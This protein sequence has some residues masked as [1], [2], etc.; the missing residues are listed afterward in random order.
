[1]SESLQQQITRLVL[2]QIEAG[3]IDPEQVR[4]IIVGLSRDCQ[5]INIWQHEEWENYDNHNDDQAIA[6]IDNQ[7]WVAQ[8]DAIGFSDE[9][10]NHQTSVDQASLSYMPNFGF[11]F[12]NETYQQKFLGLLSQKIMEIREA[13]EQIAQ[14]QLLGG[15]SKVVGLM[16]QRISNS[17]N[18]DLVCIYHPQGV[19]LLPVSDR[20]LPGFDSLY[21]YMSLVD[22]GVIVFYTDED[23]IEERTRHYLFSEMDFFKV[24]RDEV[25]FQLTNG[26]QVELGSGHTHAEWGGLGRKEIEDRL[27]AHFKNHVPQLYFDM[28]SPPVMDA[29]IAWPQWCNLFEKFFRKQLASATSE[30]LKKGGIEQAKAFLDTLELSS[31]EKSKVGINYLRHYLAQH[32]YAELI[33]CFNACDSSNMDRHDWNCVYRALMMQ[34]QLQK[35]LEITRQQLSAKLDDYEAIVHVA[36]Y[37]IVS[38]HLGHQE[39]F[40]SMLAAKRDYRNTAFY[41]AMLLVSSDELVTC[42]SNI[43]N[44][45]DYIL[46]YAEKDFAL[47]PDLLSQLRFYL[48]LRDNACHLDSQLKTFFTEPSE[49]SVID[50]E[51]VFGERWISEAVTMLKQSSETTLAKSIEKGFFIDGEHWVCLE[52]GFAR[53]QVDGTNCRLTQILESDRYYTAL[54]KVDNFLYATSNKT[55]DI[56][57]C[58]QGLPPR[59]LSE[60]FAALDRPT[61][62]SVSKG[63]AVISDGKKLVVLDVSNPELPKHLSCISLTQS[64]GRYVQCNC[65]LLKDQVLYLGFDDQ[66]VCLIDLSNPLIPVI[67]GFVPC[68]M[69]FDVMD[70]D[71]EVLVAADKTGVVAIDVSD[72][73]RPKIIDCLSFKVDYLFQVAPMSFMGGGNTS[74]CGVKYQATIHKLILDIWPLFDSHYGQKAIVPNQNG[75]FICDD[76]NVTNLQFYSEPVLKIPTAIEAKEKARIWIGEVLSQYQ[77]SSSEPLGCVKASVYP[78]VINICL[79]SQLSL[80]SMEY[81]LGSMKSW[82]ELW[83]IEQFENGYQDHWKANAY[84]SVLEDFFRDALIQIIQTE[85]QHLIAGQ[86]YININDQIVLQIFNEG[87]WKPA[88]RDIQ[89]VIEVPLATRLEDFNTWEAYARKCDQDAQLKQ[90]LYA[91]AKE[92]HPKALQVVRRRFKRD[93]DDSIAVMLF[94]IEEYSDFFW[95]GFIEKYAARQDVQQACARL[96]ARLIQAL[97]KDD[98]DLLDVAHGLVPATIMLGKQNQSEIDPL[99]DRLLFA[100]DVDYRHYDLAIKLLN[101]K[102]DVRPFA[103]IIQRAIKSMEPRDNRLPELAEQLFRAGIVEIPE[104]LIEQS[105]IEKGGEQYDSIKLGIQFLDQTS[106]YDQCRIERLFTGKMLLNNF[107]QG[108]A[109][110]QSLWPES[111]ALEPHPQSWAYLLKSALSQMNLEAELPAFIQALG[112]RLDHA[113]DRAIFTALFKTLV[114]SKDQSHYLPPMINLVRA[115]PSDAAWADLHKLRKNTEANLAWQANAEGNTELS[116]E[117]THRLLAEGH[118][119]AYLYFLEARLAWKETGDPAVA[120]KLALPR[121]KGL[122]GGAAKAHFINL[123]GCAYDA[124]GQSAEA[125]AQFKQAAEMN[126]EMVVY[127]DNITECYDKMG[128]AEKALPAAL[129]AKRR[130]SKA[131]IVESIIDKLSGKPRQMD[132]ETFRGRSLDVAMGIQKLADA[133]Y[134]ATQEELTVA[135]VQELIERGNHKINQYNCLISESAGGRRQGLIDQHDSFIEEIKGYVKELEEK[136]TE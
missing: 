92:G 21:G 47:R 93:E 65:V 5:S 128:D 71:Q 91:L 41:V 107:R 119:S 51:K 14:E 130:G 116:K 109:S 97:E 11:S 7:D 76:D 133:L 106:E 123:I 23:E 33:Q 57:V 67:T 82:N 1:M 20:P 75:F 24:E 54:D 99:V 120:I 74:W 69:S 110:E 56:F 78:D 73:Y 26:L 37:V 60:T 2:E 36:Y 31:E 55:I 61:A 30:C 100:P 86:C 135:Q 48:A 84:L 19:D 59:L 70:L 87:D 52:K 44:D 81:A 17:D 50:F 66:G 35:I 127:F 113:A 124:L 79:Y 46:D 12:A 88:R 27:I 25:I 58:E 32:Q 77:S 16:G 28:D 39:D 3:N 49:K 42:L 90:E 117:I 72:S 62:I 9:S 125:L 45:S 122:H 105:R 134:E 34:G 43:E 15:F 80:P 111:L 18:A 38:V 53:M 83:G 104:G 112:S 98:V 13:L 6:E 22:D 4:Q 132:M 103:D 63:M 68:N 108:V 114:E 121:L 96:Y 102:K 126:P 29:L 95:L 64:V 94:V 89:G 131:A 85:Y 136:L 10:A 8:L 101:S 115:L 129:D 40:V 118:E